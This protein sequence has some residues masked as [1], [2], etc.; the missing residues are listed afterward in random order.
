MGTWMRL[1]HDG[2]H[3][4]ST[5]LLWY[6]R[7]TWM[8]DLV[9]GAVDRAV[10]FGALFVR[11]LMARQPARPRVRSRSGTWIIERLH[12]SLVTSQQRA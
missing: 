2:D 11:E 3:E 4:R 7:P 1:G 12:R 6:K 9:T 8:D 10:R 5:V